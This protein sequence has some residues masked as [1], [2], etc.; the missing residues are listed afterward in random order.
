MK[1]GL[2]EDE[3]NVEKTWIWGKREPIKLIKVENL[4]KHL[5][6]IHYEWMVIYYNFL[7]NNSFP[8]I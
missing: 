1:K 6:I 5:M 8:Q 3:R 4:Y 7:R 2:I